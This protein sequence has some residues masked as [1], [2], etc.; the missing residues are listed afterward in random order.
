MSFMD[1]RKVKLR[2]QILCEAGALVILQRYADD[3][4]PPLWQ[5]QGKEDVHPL[6]IKVQYGSRPWRKSRLHIYVEKTIKIVCELVGRADNRTRCNWKNN[7][8][9]L[10]LKGGVYQRSSLEMGIIR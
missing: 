9:V 5:T 3:E 4:S 6:N 2:I 7:W 10:N 1:E 8:A